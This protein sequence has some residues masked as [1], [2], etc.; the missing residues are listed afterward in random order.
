MNAADRL[1]RFLDAQES[2]YER[3]LAEIKSGRKQS[4]WIWFI[5]PQIQG[6]GLSNMSKLYAIKDINEAG[7]FL[8]HEVL[9]KRLV[10]ISEA[11]MALETNDAHEVF[12]TPDDLKLRSSMTLFSSLENTHPVFEAVLNKFFNGERDMRTLEIIGRE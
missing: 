2:T 7:E 9:G 4:H 3:A 1:Q 11:L 5:F 6:L 10:K 12:G 8:E